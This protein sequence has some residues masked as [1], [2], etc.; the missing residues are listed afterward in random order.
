MPL[1][2]MPGGT[3]IDCCQLYCAQIAGV[4]FSK[5]HHAD[6]IGCD[7]WDGEI[8]STQ[9]AWPT[10]RPV[11]RN[12]QHAELMAE[13][14]MSGML[15]LIRRYIIPEAV[16][17]HF[18]REF[19][20]S[21]RFRGVCSLGF[22]WQDLESQGLRAFLQV[23]SRPWGPRSRPA[24]AGVHGQSGGDARGGGV[25]VPG[26][27]S[28]CVIHELDPLAPAACV[29]Q[30][31]DVVQEIEGARIADDGTIQVCCQTAATATV[32]A[33]RDGFCAAPAAAT[34][35]RKAACAEA[36]YH[37]HQTGCLPP[38]CSSATRSEWSWCM[39]CGAST[40]VRVPGLHAP[41]PHA[42]TPPPPCC[43]LLQLPSGADMPRRPRCTQG[44][45]CICRFCGTVPR[46]TSNTR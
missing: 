11:C 2:S 37:R 21:G 18:L 1:W 25:Q 31:K 23:P 14:T 44:I 39:R 13:L 3:R 5:N 28:G 24:A 16:V 12:V 45:R 10:G 42:S 34:S 7:C 32:P 36:G 33:A 6:N 41:P 29:L 9:L 35:K 46:S 17:R 22:R 38:C 26:D 40:S 43:A 20:L 4:A 27:R 19:E 30:Q 8:W 15:L